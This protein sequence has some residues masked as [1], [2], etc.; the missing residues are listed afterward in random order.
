MTAALLLSC[1]ERCLLCWPADLYHQGHRHVAK[2]TRGK[3]KSPFS[4]NS[5]YIWTRWGRSPIPKKTRRIQAMMRLGALEQFPAI[6]IEVATSLTYEIKTRLHPSQAC[7]RK[8]KSLFLIFVKIRYRSPSMVLLRRHN[9]AIWKIST[10]NELMT[11]CVAML[12]LGSG[13]IKKH[14]LGWKMCFKREKHQILKPHESE[15]ASLVLFNKDG[16]SGV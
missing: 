1:C 8:E 15:R 2:T 10:Y 3:K 7:R 14:G 9:G 6:R 4:K 13:S 5:S 12:F 16:M 11:Q